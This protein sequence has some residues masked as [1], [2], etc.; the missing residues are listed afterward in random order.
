[1]PGVDHCLI[2]TSARTGAID[3]FNAFN[4]DVLAG[5]VLEHQPFWKSVAAL[6]TTVRPSTTVRDGW[7]LPRTWTSRCLRA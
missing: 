3:Q 2:T 5:L 4:L 6:V 1:M 7:T